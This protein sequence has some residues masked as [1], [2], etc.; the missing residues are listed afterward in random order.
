MVNKISTKAQLLMALRS[1]EGKMVN[2]NTL[3]ESIGISRVA[4]WK[5]IQTLNAMGY[6]IEASAAGYLLDPR[7][8][9]DFLFPWEFGENEALFRCFDHI[10]STMDQAREIS[11]HGAP[12]G[13]VVLAERQGAGRGRNGATWSSRQ[14]G[15]YC[16]ILEN[17]SMSLA[18]Y[19]LP[20]MLYHIAAARVISSV[21]GKQARLRWPND[22]YIGS[23]KIAGI[24]TGLEGEA[25]IIQR[26]AIGIG[27]NVNN[28]IPSEKAVNCAEITGHALS[29][30][31]IL[32]KI[33]DQAGR[34]KKRVDS[35]GSYSQ[36]NRTL[37]AEWNALAFGIGGTAAV[38]NL[39]GAEIKGRVLARGIFSGID[40]AGRCIIKTEKGTLYFNPGPVS[41][42]YN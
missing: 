37:A 17:S 28:P 7:K 38:V 29:R 13:T 8:S 15:L 22:I 16:T 4:V 10:N 40:P 41:I 36:G 5:G 21:C 42:I 2:G 25:D 18:D 19:C 3:A 24:L 26:L 35:G 14:G 27:V 32:I 33:I 1:H 39:N 34:L 6:Q 12:A 20:Q 23:R 11:L 30:R 31:E 9:G